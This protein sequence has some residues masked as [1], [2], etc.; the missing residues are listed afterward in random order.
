[1]TTR[2]LHPNRD[3]VSGAVL[4]AAYGDIDQ[5]VGGSPTLA[6]FGTISARHAIALQ[7]KRFLQLLN[8]ESGTKIRPRVAIAGPEFELLWGSPVDFLPDRTRFIRSGRC[9]SE[10]GGGAVASAESI[11]T[12]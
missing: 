6:P 12:M 5:L 8:A 2:S 4:F 7:I 10:T 1:M 11:P 3:N 9:G